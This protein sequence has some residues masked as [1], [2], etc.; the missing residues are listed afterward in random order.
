MKPDFIAG[1]AA[2]EQSLPAEHIKPS[3]LTGRV[4]ARPIGNTVVTMIGNAVRRRQLE[5]SA[6]RSSRVIRD[7]L[8]PI[9]GIDRLFEVG[10]YELKD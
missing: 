3:F 5:D 7:C 1:S 2:E 4:I 8:I 6:K 9:E 10:N